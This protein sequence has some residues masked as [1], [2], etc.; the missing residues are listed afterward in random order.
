MGRNQTICESPIPSSRNSSLHGNKTNEVPDELE[1]QESTPILGTIS[2]RN[3]DY[4]S[5]VKTTIAKVRQQGGTTVPSIV[6]EEGALSR[7]LGIRE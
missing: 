6:R 5:I 3:T 4:S 7:E 1:A 2:S